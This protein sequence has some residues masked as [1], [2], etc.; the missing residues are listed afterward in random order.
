[1]ATIEALFANLNVKFGPR[2]ITLN[3]PL[4]PPISYGPLL[5]TMTLLAHAYSNLQQ[6]DS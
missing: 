1:V 6:K 5:I 2:I 4:P 3:A